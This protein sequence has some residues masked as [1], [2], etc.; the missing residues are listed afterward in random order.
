M[1]LLLTIQSYKEHIDSD[2]RPIAITNSV[3][4]AAEGRCT[5][6]A[7][8]QIKHELCQASERSNKIIR[9]LFIDFSK[10]FGLIYHNV[11]LQKFVGQTLVF[12]WNSRS[13]WC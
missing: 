5:T 12:S 8:L 10:A 3:A 13:C 9:I 6:Q 11:L 4:K 1:Q 2:V 7:L